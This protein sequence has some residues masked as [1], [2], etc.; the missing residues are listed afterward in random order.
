[1][2]HTFGQVF[3]VSAALTLTACSS[4][5][6]LVEKLQESAGSV[7][8]ASSDGSLSTSEIAAG[9]KEAL[10]KGTGDVVAQL[11]Q[12]GGFS[13]NDLIRIPL[14]SS[15]QTA[16]D[17]ADRFGMGS[18]FTE[19]EDKLN[20]AAELATPKAKS[21]FVSAINDMTVTDARSILEGSD[22]AATRY[23]EESMSDRLAEEMRPVVE[24]SLSEVGAVSTFNSLLSKYES[25]PG[26][27]D[28]DADLTGHVVDG[29]I[30]GIFEYVAEEEKAIRENPAARTTELLQRVFGSDE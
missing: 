5:G 20:E 26:A 1:M 16:K 6:E 25:I 4:S 19:L 7:L 9:L 13:D 10:T 12:T 22:D 24:S 17:F 8:S 30:D 14:P 3:L 23:F 27:P 2:K 28:L 11:G 18:S 21:L 15:L 29:G